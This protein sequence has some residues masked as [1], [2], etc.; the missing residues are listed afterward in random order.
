MHYLFTLSGVHRVTL[1]KL[2]E[3]SRATRGP[4]IY[5]SF[6]PEYM[7]NSVS[8]AAEGR[9]VASVTRVDQAGHMV[10]CT[11]LTHGNTN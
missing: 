7:Q 4:V 8:D 9:I 10:N 6:R 11:F 3:S 5:L 1:C 2:H